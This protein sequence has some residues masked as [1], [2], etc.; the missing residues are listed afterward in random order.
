MT[1]E[2]TDGL[3]CS[4]LEKIAQK[5][6]GSKKF[7]FQAEKTQISLDSKIFSNNYIIV[8]AN[9]DFSLGGNRF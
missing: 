5:D 3:K 8:K 6:F 2:T 7:W 4:V 9:E 1:F